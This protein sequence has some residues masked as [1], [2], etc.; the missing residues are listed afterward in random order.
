MKKSFL[1]VLAAG[2]LLLAGC[3]A[4]RSA[5]SVPADLTQGAAERMVADAAAAGKLPDLLE[6]AETAVFPNDEERMAEILRAAL[7]TGAL[8]ETQTST[9]E[10]MLHDVCEVN[11]PGT[12]AADFMF[13]TLTKASLTLHDYLPGKPLV[14]LFY[15]P[16]CDHCR[17]VIEELSAI[18]SQIDVLAV[19]IA[20]N[21]KRWRQSVGL[22]PEDWT[23]AFDRSGILGNDTYVIRSMPS[24]Y[25]LDA[26]R[27]VVLKNPTP[28]RLLKHL[29]TK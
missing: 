26:E 13:G 24:V 11:A 20:G 19:D 14:L 18:G 17:E 28:E 16:D 9:A 3:A 7:A 10:W 22:L 27:T 21:E 1:L 12:K 4:R 5:W 8:N 6:A 23:G 2:C 15:D 25:L 29:E